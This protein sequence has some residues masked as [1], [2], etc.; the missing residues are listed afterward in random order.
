M[1]KELEALIQEKLLGII[2]GFIIIIALLQ[3]VSGVFM[4]FIL[5][6]LLAGVMYAVVWIEE[7]KNKEDKKTAP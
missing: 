5:M 1:I 2:T 7:R 3:I 6:L 4:D